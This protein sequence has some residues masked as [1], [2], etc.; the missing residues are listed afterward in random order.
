MAHKKKKNMKE[1]SKERYE[2]PA[3]EKK[4]IAMIGK[5]AKMHKGS[6]RGK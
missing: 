4:E 1:K 3:H 2:S 5:M 6:A